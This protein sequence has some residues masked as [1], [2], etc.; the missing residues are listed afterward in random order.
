MKVFDIQAFAE[1]QHDG[2]FTLTVLAEGLSAD[3]A[4]AI[5]I[6]VRQPFREACVKVLTDNGRIAHVLDTGETRQ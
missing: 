5:S 4:S 2:T 1:E 6:A 3:Q